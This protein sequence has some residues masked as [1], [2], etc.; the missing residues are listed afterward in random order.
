MHAFIGTLFFLCLTLFLLTPL[1]GHGQ[2]SDGRIEAVVRDE[3]GTVPPGATVKL[4]NMTSRKLVSQTAV[5]ENGFVQ[6][7]VDTGR[8][9]IC[10][11]SLGY[12]EQCSD[13]LAIGQEQHPVVKHS[14]LLK[15][16]MKVLD[17]VVIV[18]QRPTIQAEG[19][20]LV[21]NTENSLSAGT[22][23][24]EL[25]KTMPGVST[26]QDDEILFR[27]TPGV[28]V[29][30]NG[31]MTYL[32]GKELAEMLNGL[33]AAD[34]AKIELLSSPSADFDAAG[35]GGV[36]NIVTKKPQEKGY[37]LEQRSTVS[38]GRYWMVNENLTG[39]YK[40]D[41]LQVDASFDY[42][43][44]HKNTISTSSHTISNGVNDIFLE[45]SNEVSFKIKFYT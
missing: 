39:S 43:T 45:R 33:N 30:V 28:Q 19:N 16:V 5:D 21:L 24:M 10:V 38:K 22:S 40:T 3:A 13:T 26:G 11:A 23:A 2:V 18:A 4:F 17:D 27:G 31:K 15:S 20:K 42:N 37:A 44:P 34:V 29:T 14:F 6:F 8:Y 35:T 36:I 12:L 1:I 41:K 9:R 25:L 32:S 7:V